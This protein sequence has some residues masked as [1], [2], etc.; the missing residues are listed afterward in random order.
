[1]QR[2]CIQVWPKLFILENKKLPYW[3]YKHIANSRLEP[4]QKNELRAWA[5][6]KMPRTQHNSIPQTGGKPIRLFPPNGIS[7][8]TRGSSPVA[9]CKFLA[10][11]KQC[12]A[13]IG[14]EVSG[15]GA[16][17]LLLPPACSSDPCT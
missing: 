11:F 10:H 1:M 13:K 14:Q 8:R 16:N 15:G 17:C 12:L 4:H 9:G 2:D 5:E 3:F 6:E 7:N